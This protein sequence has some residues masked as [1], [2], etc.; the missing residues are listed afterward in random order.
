[1][2]D[3]INAYANFISGQLVKEGVI[4]EAKGEDKAVTQKVQS[5]KSI[6]GNSDF[7]IGRDSEHF[8]TIGD[9]HGYESNA[10][11]RDS[12]NYVVHNT[13]TGKT[14]HVVADADPENDS[15]PEHKSISKEM[16]KAIHSH[17][18][19][20]DESRVVVTE[21]KASITNK[22]AKHVG[23][24]KDDADGVVNHVASHGNHHT[25]NIGEEGWTYTG[26]PASY[27][28][29]DA[30][31]GKTHNFELPAKKVTADHVHKVMNKAVP[32]GVS[33]E[34]AKAVADDHNHAA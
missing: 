33:A 26:E 17:A 16:L 12:I 8:K 23:V 22:V 3:R 18:T 20:L 30:S 13:K 11:G 28:T 19:R 25:Y 7:T 32:G 21:A 1:M 2:N 6:E 10:A 5:M 24:S 15:P 34:H 29:H 14:H 27:S 31:T 4:T 9:E